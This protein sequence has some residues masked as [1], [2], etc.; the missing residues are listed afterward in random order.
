MLELRNLVTVGKLIVESALIRHE[1]RGLHFN[2]DSDRVFLFGLGQGGDMAYDVGL[3]HPDLFAGILPVS[4]QP[5]PFTVRYWRNVQYVP[6]YA[7]LGS[8]AGGK[9]GIPSRKAFESWVP[10]G[11]AVLGVMYSGR[12]L[13]WFPAELPAMFDWMGR[14]KRA[15]PL[16]RRIQPQRHQ[17]R[18]INR[19]T[20]ARR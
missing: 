4:A 12:G 3:S 2:V 14:K 11:Y 6:I 5:G 19:R 9:Y 7:V 10:R 16:Q 15:H 13:E 8:W 18:R 20:A 1:S 17:D